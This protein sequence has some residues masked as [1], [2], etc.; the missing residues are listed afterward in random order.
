ML[1]EYE[2]TDAL[3]VSAMRRELAAQSIHR[4]QLAL[5]AAVIPFSRKIRPWLV[6]TAGAIL[7]AAAVVAISFI[8]TP[9]PKERPIAA[10]NESPGR[11]TV[12]IPKVATDLVDYRDVDHQPREKWGNVY[13][14]LIGIRGTNPNVI[15]V[16]ERQTE[17]TKRV[18][19]SSDF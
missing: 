1:S 16:I 9:S 5:Q 12:E 17:S 19:V 13:R 11:Q 3:A 10:E 15:Y 4:Q 8:N 18:P 7:T 14:D 6:G 2:K